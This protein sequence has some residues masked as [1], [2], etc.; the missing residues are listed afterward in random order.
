M[1]SKWQNIAGL[2]SNARTRAVIILTL[3]IFFMA[4][5]IG[6]LTLRKTVEKPG[7]TSAEVAPIGRIESVPGG[8]ESTEEYLRLQTLEN[9]SRAEQALE[10]GESA[11]P[12]ILRASPLDVEALFDEGAGL[13]E[14]SRRQAVE[15]F[16]DILAKEGVDENT[17]RNVLGN[18]INLLCSD[19]ADAQSKRELLDDLIK[20]LAE[21]ERGLDEAARQ[22]ALAD[23]QKALRDALR[24]QGLDDPARRQALSNLQ[25]ALADLLKRE[26][27][28][29]AAQ[30]QALADLQKALQDLL[31]R[32]AGSDAA[33]QNA[34]ADLQRRLQALLDKEASEDVA[35]Q[36]LIDDLQQRLQELLAAQAAQ[37]GRGINDR[38]N[39][40]YFDAAGTTDNDFDAASAVLNKLENARPVA[41]EDFENRVAAL[42]SAM[43][44]QASQ[45][46]ASWQPPPAQQYIEGIEPEQKEAGQT[47]A[48]GANAE[49]GQ[50]ANAQQA[51]EK[52][53]IPVGTILFGALNTSINSDEPGP[54]FATVVSGRFKGAKLIG[55]LRKPSNDAGK[56]QL[57]FNT[58]RFSGSPES[59]RVDAVAIDPKTARTALSSR[60]DYHYLLRYGSLFASAFLEGFN[61]ALSQGGQVVPTGAG[62][63][64]VALKEIAPAD[65]ALY[66]VGKVGERYAD[67]LSKNFTKPPTVYV[68]EGASMGI[69]FLT[70]VKLPV[71]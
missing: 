8:T 38:E 57:N 30:Q 19:E 56:I 11:I 18:L 59:L 42:Q 5:V 24:Q 25:Q 20:M 9:I 29:A 46:F 45:L 66:A 68:N 54:I 32:A 53:V 40:R 64:V 31:A 7:A 36:Q 48:G 61:E 34:L 65:R 2:F 51:D 55:S 3:I 63:A 62:G 37:Q 43:T 14:L 13:G 12:T 71:K 44:S 52:I 47:A 35:Q 39:N 4:I 17:R 69:L 21:R 10:R 49:N 27:Q 70:E 28:T 15:N 50:A 22:Q 67:V 23:L 33:Q 1:A 26:G 16:L 6:F 41:D 60:T 58:M